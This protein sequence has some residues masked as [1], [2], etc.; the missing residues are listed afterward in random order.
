ME[1]LRTFSQQDLYFL[2][3]LKGTH[4]KPCS[5]FPVQ[6]LDWTRSIDCILMH[7]SVATPFSGLITINWEV[8]WKNSYKALQIL[9]KDGDNWHMMSCKL[10]SWKMGTTQIYNY[11]GRDQRIFQAAQRT[12]LY[13][14]TSCK[15][16]V[17]FLVFWR[18][19]DLFRCLWYVHREEELTACGYPTYQT[20][21]FD[22]SLRV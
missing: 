6:S 16:W 8:C 15:F 11:L 12:K 2:Y 20:L 5:M 17:R 1:V 7:V 22:V 19:L 13:F 10:Y 9:W 4:L 14:V 21:V 18:V 3:D